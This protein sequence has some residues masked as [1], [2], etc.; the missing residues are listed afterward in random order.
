[1]N[2]ALIFSLFLKKHKTLGALSLLLTAMALFHSVHAKGFALAC[3]FLVVVCAMYERYLALRLAF[4]AD[5]FRCLS[6]ASLT[7]EQL[8][9]ALSDLYAKPSSHSRS[10]VERIAGTQKILR[11]YYWLIG[12]QFLLTLLFVCLQFKK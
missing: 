2:H 9:I 3:V 12:T 7:A 6:D 5:L 10:I 1:M 4:D 8:D 11:H